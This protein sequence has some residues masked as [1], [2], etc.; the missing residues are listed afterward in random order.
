[1]SIAP[2]PP[3]ATVRLQFHRDFTLEDARAT[4]PYYA[5]LGISHIYASPLLAARAGSIHGYD[6]IDPTRINPELGGLDALRRLV[7]TLR[8]HGMGLILDIVPNHMAA[9]VENP[10]WREVLEWGRDSRHATTFDIDWDTPDPE[11]HG[12]VL[13]PV[14]DRPL[15]EILSAGDIALH[16]ERDD[17]RIDVAV[18]AQR[19]PLAASAYAQVLGTSGL[20]ALAREFAAATP[21]PQ[22]DRALAALREC[23][24][25]TTGHEA[26]DHV[27]AQY[28]PAS[29][30]GREHLET[31]L[32]RQPYLLA[33]WSQAW[34]RINWRRFFD[35]NDL[36]AIRPARPEVFDAAHALVLDL[37]AQGLIDGLRID[38]IDGLLDPGGY[39][40]R[41]RGQLAAL[42]SRRPPGAPRGPAYL[43]VE[44]ILAAEELLRAQWPVEGTTGYEFMDQASAVLHDQAGAAPLARLWQEVAGA[45]DYAA[46]AL[47]ARRQ[48]TLQNFSADLDANVRALQALAAA[49]GDATAEDDLRAALVELIVHFP[50]YRTYA[51][52][53]DADPRD[54]EVL[55]SAARAADASTASHSRRTMAL[56]Q[57]WLSGDTPADAGDEAALAIARFQALTPPVAAKAIE[58]TAFYRYGRLLSRNEVGADPDHFALSVEAFHT[59]CERRRRDTPYTLLATATHDHK[60]G[61]DARAR[62]AVLSEI[63]D[64]W[65]DQVHHWRRINGNRL[66]TSDGDPAPE[67]TDQLMLYQTIVGAWPLQMRA[68]D[69]EAIRKFTERIGQW[70]SKALREAKS[71]SSW[72]HPDNAY[73]AACAEFL[74]ACMSSS[75]FLDSVSGFVALIAPAGALNGLS[76]TLLRLT[77]PG[78][79]DLYQGT[80]FWDFS[81]V[82]P[83]NRRPVDL[84][85]REAALQHPEAIT[86][87]LAGW[88]DGHLKQQL[89]ARVLRARQ[90]HPGL[91]RDGSYR[92]LTVRGSQAEHAIVFQ[93]DDGANAAIVIAPRLPWPLLGADAR[94][95]HVDASCWHDTA[96]DLPTGNWRDVVCQR[97]RR[98]TGS[99]PL[100]EVLDRGPVALLLKKAR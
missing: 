98:F 77:T 40:R 95:P 93:R 49:T 36:V 46:Q 56:L 42:E 4:V 21:G 33:P 73:E 34:R 80:E 54:A 6:V 38:H 75:D 7:T 91:F 29:A 81:L 43:I 88:T 86:D 19:F 25:T 72:S 28:S 99:T 14:L 87:L 47:A 70:Q 22:F 92:P 5:A 13:L 84:V 24:Q 18:G 52:P 76:Q 78:V 50:V 41:L 20:T 61:E 45:D 79:P 32:A 89:I 69:R 44:K 51:K 94:T 97:E 100:R 60:R 30:A 62:L 8:A 31:L 37:Y 59:A 23:A 71:R 1:M 39:C 90:E 65:A 82:D 15:D 16:H 96:V 64:A 2:N 66:G 9:S 57:R 35:I 68:T 10:W 27:L 53:G 48:M 67:P 63:P 17:G 11:L 3:G 74:Q 55:A 83:D 26:I 85:A 58:D 12:R